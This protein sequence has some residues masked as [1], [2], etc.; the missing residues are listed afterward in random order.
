M[1]KETLDALVN[2]AE[3]L[4]ADPDTKGIAE[5][6]HKQAQP[7]A[8]HF[9]DMGH[10]IEREASKATIKT[11]EEAKIK[12][13]TDLQEATKTIEDLRK[14]KPDLAGIQKQHEDALRAAKDEGKKA[15]VAE[16]ERNRQFLMQRDL[17]YLQGYLTGKKVDPEIAKNLTHENAT[18]PDRIKHDENGHPTVFQAGTQ[19]P[20]MVAQ[21][22]QPLDPLGEELL[23][24]VP[25]GAFTE[26]VDE[27]TEVSGHRTDA[28]GKG[29]KSTVYDGIR[30]EAKKAETAGNPTDIETRRA[31]K[32]GRPTATR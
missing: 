3:K 6:L 2:L 31:Q 27:G 17:G 30:E 20:Y 19:T 15:V 25:K 4:K 22:Q 29:G 5:A 10:G 13:E 24:R 26:E 32:F 14:D 9:I 23:K 8:Q 7:L 16:K 1:E 18:L 28:G 11:A 21:G 12:A